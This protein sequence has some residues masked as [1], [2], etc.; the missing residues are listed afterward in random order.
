MS[1]LAAHELTLQFGS[2][3]IFDGDSVTVEPKDRLGIVGP[4]GTGKSTLLK[5]LTGQVALDKGRVVKAK[6]LRVGYLAQE[7]A[8]DGEVPLL[9]SVLRE[10]PGKADLE[11]RL[12]EVEAALDKAE[13]GEEQLSLSQELAEIH[14]ELSDVERHFAPHEGNRILLG[15]G[16]QLE[17]LERPVREFSGGWRMRAALAALLFQQPEVLILD[18]PTNHLDMPSV[19]WLNRFLT[20]YRHALVLVC[21]DKEFLNKHVKRIASFEV[22]GLRIYKG[23]FDDYRRQ[24]A[25]DLEILENKFKKDEARKKELESFVTRFKAKASKARQAQSKM[26][27][28]EKLQEE[29]EEVPQLRRSIHLSFRPTPPSGDPVLESEDLAFSYG[30]H[31]VLDQVRVEVRKG[32]RVAIVGKNGAGKTTLLKLIAGELVPDSGGIQFSQRTKPSYFAQ[33]HADVLDPKSSVLDEVWRAAPEITQSAARTLCGSFLFSGDEVEKPISVLSGGEKTR[34]AMA[35]I[36]V[37]P[38]NLLLL[39][40]PTNHLDTDSAEKLVDSLLTFDGTILFVSHNLDFARRLSN[41]VWIV[42]NGTVFPFPGSL[43]DYLDQVEEQQEERIRKVTG[44]PVRVEAPKKKAAVVRP[45]AEMTKAERI[46][47]REAQKQRK[48]ELS[49]LE[50]RLGQLEAA[51]ASGETTSASL[52]KQMEDPSLYDDIEKSERV[53]SDHKAA[54]EALDAAMAEWEDVAARLEKLQE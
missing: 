53:A 50:K 12:A 27:M 37:E 24:R 45:V 28:I 41:K 46:Q 21:H 38:G 42:E 29:Q 13:E 7:W 44:S 3:V 20:G 2:K 15:L 25:L 1:L 39:D 32:D 23:N 43:A 19:F 47:D 40:E 54:R 33:H 14:V 30:D 36:L 5:V 48:R 17:D 16:F 49:R 26:R 18:E 35:R 9:E 4:N 52:E 22:E 6:G 11:A 8:G 51:I 10:A 31:K 34:V